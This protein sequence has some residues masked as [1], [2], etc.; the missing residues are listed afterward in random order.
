MKLLLIPLDVDGSEP[1][2]PARRRSR[3]HALPG[4]TDQL[5]EASSTSRSCRNKL[6]AAPGEH[7]LIF[8]GHSQGSINQRSSRAIKKLKQAP[9]SLA[10]DPRPVT[11]AELLLENGAVQC[12]GHR[13]S[14]SAIGLAPATAR[15]TAA[16]APW[17]KGSVGRWIVI[18]VV[19]VIAISCAARRTGVS[20]ASRDYANWHVTIALPP[21]EV[22]R[23]ALGI[24]DEFGTL[25][26]SL[27]ELVYPLQ[28]KAG[29][30]AT[31]VLGSPIEDAAVLHQ[32]RH[33]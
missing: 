11:L 28:A 14:H 24:P 7:P 33:L 15:A 21:Q 8:A 22:P 25:W 16:R 27:G 6:S 29:D 23:A 32:N 13:P 4:W 3:D 20:N 2:R 1:H 12:P 30:P 17:Y 5:W 19:G 9:T 10:R 18:I 26:V 31:M